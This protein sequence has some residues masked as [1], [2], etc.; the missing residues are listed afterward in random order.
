MNHTQFFKAIKENSLAACYLL[1][2]EEEY[3]KRS[4]LEAVK[5][6]VLPE[7][8]EALNETTL[9]NPS[10]DALTAALE[11]M[12]FMADRRLVIATECGF[13][14]GKGKDDAQETDRL[15]QYLDALPDYALL[16]FFVR[17]NADG[18]KK[19]YQKLKARDAIVSF[20]PL[21]DSELT[22][23]IGQTLKPFQ[24]SISRDTAAYL[25]FAVGRDTALL[26]GEL[27][28]LAA[29]AGEKE[30]ITRED[31]DAV[32]IKSVECTVFQL[33]DEIVDGRTARAMALLASLLKNGNERIAIL[34]MVLR[35]YRILYHLTLMK[36][37]GMSPRE[38]QSALGIP[39]FAAE[40]AQKQA[41]AYTRDA[42]KAAVDSLIAADLA[43]K[44]GR[45]NQDG[46]L[47]NAILALGASRK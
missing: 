16:L 2:G 7:G 18:R 39:P 44:S 8:L 30:E 24:K 32:C 45:R 1:E 3:I 5:K 37:D 10:V 28:K 19:I 25:A 40:R 43:V 31:I 20:K 23:W 14:G 29:H 4:A 36:E 35:Q 34:Q 17:G 41:R 38:I 13:L 21:D 22:R 9:E 26:K 46:A 6:A 47:E 15:N 33:T 11:T 27:S 42:L 12:P